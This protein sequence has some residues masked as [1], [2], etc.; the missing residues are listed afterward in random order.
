MTPCF[1]LFGASS[2]IIPLPMTFHLHAYWLPDHPK[3]VL[4]RE[5]SRLCGSGR[6]ADVCCLW[7]P[8]LCECESGQWPGQWTGGDL[9]SQSHTVHQ[10]SHLHHLRH[11]S[12]GYHRW[13]WWEKYLIHNNIL[14]FVFP[15]ALFFP[16]LPLLSVFFKLPLVFCCHCLDILMF[17]FCVI[18]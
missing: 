8:A 14:V 7:E 16:P 1:F 6:G 5:S 4:Y 11:W 18:V 12:G 3:F 9:L 10:I 2:Y 17:C 15:F 13:R